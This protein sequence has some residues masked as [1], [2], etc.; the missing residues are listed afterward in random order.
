MK[1][2]QLRMRIA[3]CVLAVC[4]VGSLLTGCGQNG[5]QSADSSSGAGSGQEAPVPETKP[6]PVNTTGKQALEQDRKLNVAVLQMPIMETKDSLPYLDEAVGLL[7]NNSLR[8]EL[9][10]GVEYGLGFSP[11]RLDGEFIE[12]LSAIAKKYQIY[13]IPGTFP[14]L[15]DELPEGETF[16]T[17]PIFG[18]D[19]QLICAYRKK[20]P[21][22]PGELSTPSN[23][24]EYCLFEIPEKG[25]KVGV[26]ICYEQFFPEVVRTL[27][28]E[29]AELLVCPAYD[30]AEFDYIPEVIPRCRALENEAFY[31]YTNGV[32]SLPGDP[33][34]HSI[35]VD[36]RGQV[37]YRADSSEMSFTTCLDFAQ[38]TEKR[39]YG[40]DQHLNAL[41]YFDLPNPY[42]GRVDEAPVYKDWPELTVTTDD[43]DQ[44]VAEIGENTMPRYPDA[45]MQAEQSQKMEKLIEKIA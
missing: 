7:M 30:T 38:V 3:A 6:Q 36:P 22:Y 40:V 5:G 15:S 37:L 45:G 2:T 29:G 19:G 14:E 27:A 35:V 10:V 20:A 42:A 16:N 9:V 12:Y 28:L 34:G 31:V 41:R 11:Q 25:I 33:F 23:Q 1:G 32:G 24:E 8:P 26:M 44:R 4:L 18:P 13:F 39:L 21:F 43:F 17:C